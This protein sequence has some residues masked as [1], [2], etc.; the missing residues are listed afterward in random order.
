MDKGIVYIYLL[1]SLHGRCILHELINAGIPPRAVLG[2]SRKSILKYRY[3]SIKRYFSKIGIKETIARAIYKTLKRNSPSKERMK[4]EFLSIREQARKYSIPFIF[5]DD[6]NDVNSI[7]LLQSFRPDFFVLGG[8]PILKKAVLN[9]PQ[10]G[11]ISA[12]P[13]KLPDIR[14]VDVVGWSVYEGIPTGLTVFLVDQG[15]D[16]GP[17]LYFHEVP[18]YSGLTLEQLEIKVE[19]EAGKA[20]VHAI[21]SLFSGELKPIPQRKEVGK[22]YGSMTL[23][24]RKKIKQIL[25]N[26]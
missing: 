19:G 4:S 17:I 14:G 24:M 9:I 21:Q 13:A 20:V 15:I 26:R 8:A 7:Q 11:V 22:Y 18:H 5:F 16:T 1:D 12:H 23:D 25:L 10:Y 3:K 2:A 6:L